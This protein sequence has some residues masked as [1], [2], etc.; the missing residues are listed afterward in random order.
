L[1]RFLV[2]NGIGNIVIDASS[3]EVNRRQ[4]RVKTDRVDGR[5][6]LANLVRFDAG[7]NNV[8][9]VLRVPTEYEEDARRPHR[10]RERLVSEQRAHVARIKSLLVMHNV[11]LKR[12]GGQGWQQRLEA[13]GVPAKLRTELER[14]AERL[15]LV[16]R[17]I[18]QLEREHAKALK[19][20]DTQACAKQRCLRRLRGVGP[21]GAWT[22]VG[23][24]FGWRS[25]SN[26]RELAGSVGLGASPYDSGA[27]Q[28]EQGITKAGNR[29][30]RTLMVELAWAWLRFQPDSALAKWYTERFAGGGRSRRIGI[31]ALA[32]RLLIALW[33]FV[34]QGLIPQ[35]AKL[36]AA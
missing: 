16:D 13:L 11:R 15:A 32:R 14:E 7:E 29:R 33:R 22:L 4:R 2:G 28:R 30:V 24:L 21:I 1:H 18:A 10:E 6:L 5:K 12:V 35:G 25:F 26:R 3:I 36:K 23:E 19:A 17:Q 31:V 34:E 27:V 8:W 9:S 20:S